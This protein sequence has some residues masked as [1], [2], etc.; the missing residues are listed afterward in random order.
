MRLVLSARRFRLLSLLLVVGLIAAA[1]SSTDTAANGAA[2]ADA[3]SESGG[4]SDD[5]STSGISAADLQGA[6]GPTEDELNT[7]AVAERFG[8]ST[9]A[10]SV[11]VGGQTMAPLGL[12]DTDPNELLI[13]DAEIL[14]QFQS[15]LQQSSGSGVLIEVD[16]DQFV[17]TNFHVAMP[18]LVEGTSDM[19]SDSTIDATFGSNED[20]SF[21][22]QVVGVNPSFDLALLEP[23]SGVTLPNVEPIPIGD[24]DLAVKGQKT[25]AL[26][27]PF[28]LGVTLTTGNISSIGRLV[29]SIGQVSV[30]MIQTDAA[31]NP[32]NSGGALLS[33]SGELVGI[34][35]AIFNPEA[36]A[37]AGIGFAVPSN[38]LVEALANLE[39]GGVSTLTDTRPVFG[40]NLGTLALLPASIREEA[41]LPDSGIAVLDLMPGG[42]AESA[43]LVAP[44]FANV[45]G[46]AVP[47]DPDIIVAIDGAPVDTAE[48]LNLSITYDA[49][50]GQVVTLTILRGGAEV[51]IPVT[52]N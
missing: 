4:D 42:P 50:I 28:G 23:V 22:L 46:L 12:D 35:T 30:P 43:G 41:G 5:A 17:V 21:A 29:T 47:I 24:S 27:N 40:A 8:D 39:L 3:N 9:A 38:L 33:S 2:V 52:L 25:I 13:P 51:D 6:F 15:P 36:R 10:L 37:F 45:Q 18:T 14:P 44:E 19:R 49:D 48:D 32:G 34:N 26:G 20:D 11:S 1:C 7:I 16:G 31:I